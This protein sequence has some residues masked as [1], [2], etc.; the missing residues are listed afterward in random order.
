MTSWSL[1]A[2]TAF[3]VLA[4]VLVSAVRP[5]SRS[6]IRDIRPCGWRSR[7]PAPRCCPFAVDEEGLRVDLLPLETRIICVCPSHQFPLGVTMSARRRKALI[8]FAQQHGA[9]IIERL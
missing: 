6:K 5:W 3:D 4:R 1:P 7:P 8:Q 2:P 9:V